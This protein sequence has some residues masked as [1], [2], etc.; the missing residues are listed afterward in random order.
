MLEFAK[1]LADFASA[2]GKEHIIVM[3]SLDSGKKPKIDLPR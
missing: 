3:S 2:S 1:S